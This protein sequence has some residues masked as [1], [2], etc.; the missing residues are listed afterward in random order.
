MFGY[1][2][3]LTCALGAIAFIPS[4]YTMIG[5][6]KIVHRGIVLLLLALAAGYFFAKHSLRLKPQM[7]RGELLLKLSLVWG[8]SE[9]VYHGIE[10]L[11]LHDVPVREFARILL[12]ATILMVL[13]SGIAAINVFSRMKTSSDKR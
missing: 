6:A 3:I 9:L 13:I 7:G 12:F 2:V 5:E 11:I 1:C 10:K 8:I 4:S